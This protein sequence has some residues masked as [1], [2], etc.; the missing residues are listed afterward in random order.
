MA[1]KSNQIKNVWMVTREYDGL[2]G[3]GGVKDVSRQLAHALA[4]A[5][6]KITVI[7]PLYGMMDKEYLK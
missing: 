3:A 7:M 2:A 4:R 5:G 1:K 6:I